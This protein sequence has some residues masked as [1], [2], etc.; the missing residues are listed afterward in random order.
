M[1]KFSGLRMFRH[2]IRRCHSTG[3]HFLQKNV[4]CFNQC[5]CSRLCSL[6]LEVAACVVDGSHCSYRTLLI[7]RRYETLYRHVGVVATHESSDVNYF[8]LMDL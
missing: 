7:R 1:R 8:S 2:D 3:W 4:S 5:C 6:V